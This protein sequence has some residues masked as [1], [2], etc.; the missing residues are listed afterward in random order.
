MGSL[1]GVGPFF[2]GL[3]RRR[4]HRRLGKPSSASVRGPRRCRPEGARVSR[5]PWAG[6]TAS[7]SGGEAGGAASGPRGPLRASFPGIRKERARPRGPGVA[8]SLAA[9]ARLS[10]RA[11]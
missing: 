8:S 10:L 2:Q 11:A 3:A 5:G 4:G 9:F 1:P 6:G 7:V